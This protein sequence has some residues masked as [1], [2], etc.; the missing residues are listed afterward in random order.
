MMELEMTSL[1]QTTTLAV[2]LGH[3]AFEGMVITLDCELGAG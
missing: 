1:E 3:R 2:T